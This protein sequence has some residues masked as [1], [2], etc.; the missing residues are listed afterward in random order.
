[1]T[2]WSTASRAFAQYGHWKSEKAITVTGAFCGPLLG[3]TAA[4]SIRGAGSGVSVIWMLACEASWSSSCPCA[5]WKRWLIRYWPIRGRI[6]SY[7]APPI[8]PLLAS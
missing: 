4:I 3:P 7:G 8:W 2:T 5:C 1:M 6:A